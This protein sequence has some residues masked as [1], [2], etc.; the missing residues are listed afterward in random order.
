MKHFK[1]CREYSILHISNNDFGNVRN[2]R[3]NQAIDYMNTF[4]RHKAVK[5]TI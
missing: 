5:K 3:S 4:I 1:A 2:Y